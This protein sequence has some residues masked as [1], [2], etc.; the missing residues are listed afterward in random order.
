MRLICLP[1]AAG[2]E[3]HAKHGGGG[4]FYHNRRRPNDRVSDIINAGRDFARRN[5]RHVRLEPCLAAHVAL[6]RSPTSWLIPSISTASRVHCAIEIENIRPDRALATEYGRTRKA[7][8]QPAPQPRFRRRHIAH[9]EGERV[10][11]STAALPAAT[12]C[13]EGAGQ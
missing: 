8:A 12:D 3:N 7:S 2:E 9:L 4:S 1:C 6:R 5:P 11:G 10:T 13:G